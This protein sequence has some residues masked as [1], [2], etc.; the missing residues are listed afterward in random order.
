MKVD[1]LLRERLDRFA[2]F[3]GNLYSPYE[4]I[5][6]LGIVSGFSEDDLND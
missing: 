1:E 3:D 2:K 5:L 6:Q 4:V